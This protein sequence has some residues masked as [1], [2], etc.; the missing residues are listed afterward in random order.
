MI[1]Q[2]LLRVDA[3]DTNLTLPL[4]PNTLFSI[5]YTS[6]TT[7]Q[8]KG[9]YCDHLAV[10]QRLQR[11]VTQV[12]FLHKIVSFARAIQALHRAISLPLS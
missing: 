9:I 10:L 5:I 2:E 3:S 8:P 7:G 4:G 1:L 12:H 6:G 11:F